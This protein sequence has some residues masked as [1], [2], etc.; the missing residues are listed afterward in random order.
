MNYYAHGFRFLHDPYFLAGTALP[1]W[2]GVVDRKLRL[3]PNQI[4]HWLDDSDPSLRS[5]AAGVL[6]HH[7]DDEAFHTG[8]A[9]ARLQVTF[10]KA[11][12]SRDPGATD[13]A[14]YLLAHI[15]PELMLDALLIECEP[16][17]LDEYY[18]VV[19][20][21]DGGHLSA[22]IGRMAGREPDSLAKFLSIFHRERFLA[23]YGDDGR[24]CYRLSQVL[25]RVG[26]GPLPEGFVELVPSMRQAVNE[27][28]G[29]LISFLGEE[30]PFGG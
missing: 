16:T 7:E 26:W 2:L 6:R 29:D 17:R 11:I 18:E 24:L 4:R 3:P 9:F 14:K 12:A 5:L 30:S 28:K 23:D 27:V 21:L 8:A 15:V 13:L 20:S 22:M 19:L 25:T 1:D 10:A